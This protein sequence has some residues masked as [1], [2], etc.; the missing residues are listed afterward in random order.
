MLCEIC[1]VRQGVIVSGRQYPTCQKCQDEI[2]KEAQQGTH[3]TQRGADL[4]KARQICPHSRNNP[5]VS[6]PH[7][8]AHANR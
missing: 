8:A 4:L 3:L 1:G 6:R 2:L 5:I 7:R